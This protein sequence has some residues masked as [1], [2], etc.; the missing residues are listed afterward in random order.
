MVVLRGFRT[1]VVPRVG[2]EEDVAS[3]ERLADWR[4]QI[5]RMRRAVRVWDRWTANDRDALSEILQPY[6]PAG[7]DSGSWLYNDPHFAQ[8]DTPPGDWGVRLISPAT[9]MP[10][11]GGEDA[12]ALALAMLMEWVRKSNFHRKVYAPIVER[13]G[14]S[15][16]RFHDWRHYHASQLVELGTNPRVVQ[17]RIG[18][19]DVS[20]TLRF[21]VHPRHEAHQA[22]ADQFDS[23]FRSAKRDKQA[24]A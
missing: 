8:Y 20:T 21:Y 4:E 11:F 10:P 22:A 15:D 9:G 23:V 13:A 24:G 1:W 5:L 6:T 19:A 3:G 2:T 12:T 14:L 7:I 18:H 17:E 16:I